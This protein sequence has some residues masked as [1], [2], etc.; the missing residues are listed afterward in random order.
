MLQKCVRKFRLVRSRKLFFW[1]PLKGI[2][3]LFN[4]I[5]NSYHQELS[6]CIHFGRN[7]DLM[8]PLYLKWITQNFTRLGKKY[9]YK[10]QLKQQMTFFLWSLFSSVNYLL[11]TLSWVIY[12]IKSLAVNDESAKLLHQIDMHYMTDMKFNH[13]QVLPFPFF[14]PCVDGNIFHGCFR[15]AAYLDLGSF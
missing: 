4:L 2:I 5:Y 15:K 3:I 13:V 10:D 1:E 8:V 11:I 7:C 9:L 14:Y 6:L 12:F